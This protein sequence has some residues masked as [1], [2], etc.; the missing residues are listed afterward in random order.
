MHKYK[1][2]ALGISCC[3]VDLYTDYCLSHIVYGSC[4]QTCHCIKQPIHQYSWH[5]AANLVHMQQQSLCMQLIKLHACPTTVVSN[6]FY[7]TGASV[8]HI[9]IHLMK[10]GKL[11]DSVCYSKQR[12]CFQLRILDCGQLSLKLFSIQKH[13]TL[14]YIVYH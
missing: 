2:L 9:T 8:Y 6:K 13:C 7:C 12:I 14:L 5:H 10:P 3:P 11:C 4:L 1:T